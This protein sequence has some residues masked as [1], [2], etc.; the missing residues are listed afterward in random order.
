M[1]IEIT[2]YLLDQWQ[3]VDEALDRIEKLLATEEYNYV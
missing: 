2:Q 3:E 1:N